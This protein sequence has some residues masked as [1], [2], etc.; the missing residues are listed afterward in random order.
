MKQIKTNK[1]MAGLAYFFELIAIV[2]VLAAVWAGVGVY[3]TD[4]STGEL[5]VILNNSVDTLEGAGTPTS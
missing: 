4:P 2:G 1:E 3:F 5:S